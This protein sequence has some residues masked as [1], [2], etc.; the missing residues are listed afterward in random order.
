MVSQVEDYS[1]PVLVVGLLDSVPKWSRVCASADRPASMMRPSKVLL[2]Y[3][4]HQGDHYFATF[5]LQDMF[6]I[7]IDE[8]SNSIR[9]GQVQ[10]AS[11]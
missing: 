6:N 2:R 10:V 7:F 3:G 4:R 9:S 5:R 8:A 11:P 1:W